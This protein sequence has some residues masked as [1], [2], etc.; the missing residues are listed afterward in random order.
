MRISFTP[1][2]F[3]VRLLRKHV[4]M[5]QEEFWPGLGVTQSGGSRYESG[6]IMPDPVIGLMRLAYKKEIRAL[7]SKAH[8]KEKK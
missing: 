1:L 8:R 4:N 5:S 2:P 7:Q 6:R 3:P